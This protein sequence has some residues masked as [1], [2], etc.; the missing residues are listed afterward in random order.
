MNDI[1]NDLQELYSDITEDSSIES[2]D[3]NIDF[4]SI[5]EFEDDEEEQIGY[6]NDL[7]ATKDKP[8]SEE[9][10]LV[11]Q[12]DKDDVIEGNQDNLQDT[13]VIADILKSKGIDDPEA[14]Q[15]QDEN[16]NLTEVNFYD[17][18]Y[19]EQ[20][21]I[22]KT[23]EVA[24]DF[25]EYE[26]QVV[27][28]L[29]ENEITFEDAIE[30]YK[31]QAV[32][33]YIKEQ[34]SADFEI[35]NYSDDELFLLDLKSKYDFLN[36]DQLAS[37]LEKEK[38][39]LEIFE[40]K[41][42]KIRGEY[43]EIESKEKQAEL[44]KLTAKEAEEFEALKGKLIETASAIEDIGGIKLDVP[45]KNEILNFA[46]TKD[47]NN[48]TALDKVLENP[49]T[50]FE[51]A[52]YASKGKDA[53]EFIHTYYKNEIDKVNKAAYTK[54]KEDASKGNSS[55]KERLVISDKKPVARTTNRSS[56]NKV[57]IDDLYNTD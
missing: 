7:N 55:K 4:T 2:V 10:D 54:G 47:I 37:Q 22:L 25:T 48:K 40:K 24:H 1:T 27:A 35:D 16:G 29:R 13:D 46:L 31:R 36:E 21:E 42:E 53:F 23:P 15:Y 14:I 12:D 49:Q 39:D 6:L 44:E 56:K 5:N 34:S 57:T 8:S 43:K 45:E 33:E 30:Y 20:L 32:E 3:P 19:E 38:L 52:W 26:T 9:I 50:M 18:P 17:L 28:F 41:M 11:D 51:L